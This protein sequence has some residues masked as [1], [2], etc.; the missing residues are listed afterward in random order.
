[1][2]PHR[3]A[4]RCLQHPA[5]TSLKVLPRDFRVFCS[6]ILVEACRSPGTRSTDKR[7]RRE[8]GARAE[9]SRWRPRGALDS[10]GFLGRG[11]K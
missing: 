4:G 11:E 9:P 6:D 2:R 1:M 7:N 3:M 5:E 10:E 8:G